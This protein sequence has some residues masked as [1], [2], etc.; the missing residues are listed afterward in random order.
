MVALE[1]PH[2]TSEEYLERER[3]AE[4]KS[5]HVAGRV[6][7]MA[8]ATD[9]HNLVTLN[10]AGELRN[11]L[12]GKACRAYAVDIRVQVT[13]A[14]SYFYPEVIV[15]CGQPEFSPGRRDTLLSAQVIFEILS[16]STEA[17]DRGAKFFYYRQ[18]ESLTDYLLVAQDAMRIEHFTRQPNGPWV[19]SDASGPAGVI[20]IPSIGCSLRLA[21][22]YERTDFES[23][24]A[25]G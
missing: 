25:G 6:V 14:G 1:E 18:L 20:E 10:I 2:I 22:V 3:A 21:E 15:V 4:T 11:A 19:L 5:E 9:S 17:Y 7:A 16:P 24:D 23:P 13:A 12:K 8:G